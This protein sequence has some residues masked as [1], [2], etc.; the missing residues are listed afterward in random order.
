MTNFLKSIFITVYTSLLALTSIHGIIQWLE[1]GVNSAWTGILVALLPSLLFFVRLFV[2]PVPRTS[3]NLHTLLILAV[4]G[5]VLGLLLATSPEQEFFTY[6][7]SFGLAIGGGVLYIY[8]YSRLGRVPSAALSVGK[9]LPTFSLKDSNGESWESNQ[10]GNHPVLLLFFRGNW[11]PLC[12]AQIKEIAAQYRELDAMGVKVCLVSPQPEAHTQSL[13]NRF[14]VN[15]HFMIDENNQVAKELGIE[16]KQGT[17]KGLEV[18]GYDSD[19]VL[20]TAVLTGKD[21]KIIFTDQT[22]NYRVRPEP[23]TFLRIFREHDRA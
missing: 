3:S 7:Y 1:N 22:D 17:P 21:G 20:P 5:A 9:L 11:C 2:S 13:A 8:W 14:D 15:F 18:L 6:L 19:T 23:E 10:P 16:A 4:C 12:M